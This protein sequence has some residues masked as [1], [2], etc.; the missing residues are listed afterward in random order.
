MNKAELVAAMAE[1]TE[2]SK[3]DEETHRAVKRWL[4]R[5][6]KLQNSKLVKL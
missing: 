5:L 2:L 4:F 6:L 1:K 3:K